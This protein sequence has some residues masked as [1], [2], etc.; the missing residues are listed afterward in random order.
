MSPKFKVRT[1]ARIPVACDVKYVAEGLI[2]TGT[3]HDFSVDGWQ[4][5]GRTPVR[6]GM[7]LAL[8]VTLPNELTP[9]EVEAA[10]VQWV[11][12]RAFGVQ[13]VRMSAEAEARVRRFVESMVNSSR[14]V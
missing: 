9:I 5:S 1:H 6:V 11:K 14:V 10:T 12:G 7:S 8:R 4:I 13:I 3:V 2:G